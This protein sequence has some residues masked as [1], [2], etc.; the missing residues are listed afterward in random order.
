MTNM[1]LEQIYFPQSGQNWRKMAFWSIVAIGI[2][3]V[4]IE[5]LK[6]PKPSQDSN[7]EEINSNKV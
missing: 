4:T 2:V 6:T 5:V 7:D 1:Q 3:V